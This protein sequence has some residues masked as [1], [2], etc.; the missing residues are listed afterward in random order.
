MAGLLECFGSLTNIKM[1]YH[2]VF[3][4]LLLVLEICMPGRFSDVG[5]GACGSCKSGMV[6]YLVLV[7]LMLSVDPGPAWLYVLLL[8]LESLEIVT[9]GCRP[10]VFQTLTS[11][12]F[13]LFVNVGG[14]FNGNRWVLTRWVKKKQIDRCLV[15]VYS[16]QITS[17]WLV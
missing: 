8:H 16:Y 7:K 5:F 6:W 11:F 12:S 17:S 2:A 13:V 1:L 9:K 15:D 3:F 10:S 14:F 4:C